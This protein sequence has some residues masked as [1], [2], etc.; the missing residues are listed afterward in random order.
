M[1]ETAIALLEAK[2]PAN[3][4]SHEDLEDELLDNIS[5]YFDAIGSSFPY[6]KVENIFF[7]YAT[8]SLRG[9]VDDVLDPVL[10]HFRKP[11]TDSVS[12]KLTDIYLVGSAEMVEW[13]RTKGGRPIYYEGDPMPSAIKYAQKHTANLIKNMDDTTRQ[14]V[15]DTISNAIRDKRGI[16]GLA[17]DLRTKFSDMSKSRSRTIARTET[18]DALEQAFMDRANDMGINGKEWVV[19]LPCEMCAQNAG[20]IL[21]LD[22][23]FPSGHDRPPAHPN[24]RC[25]LAPVIIEDMKNK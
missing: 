7:S 2:I 21:P 5:Q 12:S 17:R 4:A 20:I 10:A 22:G 9:D 1:L 6:D 19:T 8:E 3:P 16:D 14:D 23:V 25:A 11:F 24:C 15:R 13:G 18:C